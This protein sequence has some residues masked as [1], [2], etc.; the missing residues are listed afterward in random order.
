M[1]TLA[2]KTGFNMGL[3]AKDVHTALEIVQ[4]SKTPALLAAPCTRIWD[5]AAKALGPAADHTAMFRF[6]EEKA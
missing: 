1:T 4:A 3:M 5:D 2:G 6:L